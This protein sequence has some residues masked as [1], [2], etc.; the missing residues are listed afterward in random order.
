M[1]K[2]AHFA[3]VAQGSPVQSPGVDTAL[4]GTLCCGRRPTYKI[5]EE[6]HDASSGPGFLSKKEEDGQ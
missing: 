6:E 4:L 5:E 3:S 1:V 2:F